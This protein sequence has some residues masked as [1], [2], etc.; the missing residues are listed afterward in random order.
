[1]QDSSI[2]SRS[3]AAG[4][5]QGGGGEGEVSLN[6]PRKSAHDMWL[7]KC[8]NTLNKFDQIIFTLSGS[9]D[10]R[11]VPYARNCI[12]CVLDDSIS[13][14]LHA[15]L[16]AALDY[17][18]KSDLDPQDKGSLQIEACQMAVGQVNKHMDEVIGL[19]KTN[20]IVPISS[21]P[22]E[23]EVA[24]AMDILQAGGDIEV[25]GEEMTD[26]EKL[27]EDPETL[28]KDEEPPK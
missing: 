5:P 13:D 15:A 19:I 27:K 9:T 3:I 24:A 25:G 8:L 26:P 14:A 16:N 18:N 28:V 1:M 17:I 6:M 4:S 12:N 10:P 7:M 22:S 11:V 20:A 23:A 21:D 2:D